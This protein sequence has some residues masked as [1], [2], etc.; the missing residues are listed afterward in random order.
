MVFGATAI[1][2]TTEGHEHLGAVLG[3]RSYFKEN[4]GQKVEDW[5]SRVIKMAEF[6]VSQPQA[7][8]AAYKFGPRHRW[9]YFLRTL[10][11]IADLL[12]PLERAISD[13][14]IAVLL[15]H[16]VTET[17]RDLLALPLPVDGSSKSHQPV[18]TGI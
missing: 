1:N 10:P 9:T 18:P 6:A 15:E 7:S 4:V 2:I 11:D 8:Y 13:F 12:D 5:V 14:L 16:Q 3:S 17:E